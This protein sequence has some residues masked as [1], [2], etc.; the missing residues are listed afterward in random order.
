MKDT[1]GRLARI[2]SE[3]G[4]TLIELLVAFALVAILS[5]I[6]L[7]AFY[8]YR[9]DVEYTKAEATL[10]NAQTAFSAFEVRDDELAPGYA[11]A[12]TFSATDGSP[13]GN[14][15]S[16]V[17]PGATVSEEVRLGALFNSCAG[18]P[19]ATEKM[20]LLAQPCHAQR[21]VSWLKR[22]DGVEVMLRNV[23]GPDVC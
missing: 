16:E 20:L 2:A 15:L 21:Y 5:A 17:L 3:R 7:S 6:S 13:L 19:P 12:L 18:V 1:N 11:V 22:C 23:A 10:R 8:V 9:E 14:P 4:F